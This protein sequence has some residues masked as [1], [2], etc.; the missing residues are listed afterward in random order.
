MA[1]GSEACLL[2]QGIWEDM[3]LH[4][5]LRWFSLKSDCLG[6]ASSVGNLFFFFFFYLD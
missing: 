5:S 3:S 4:P 1:A 6:A 2:S